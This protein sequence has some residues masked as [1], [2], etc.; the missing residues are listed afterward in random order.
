MSDYEFGDSLLTFVSYHAAYAKTTTGS[1]YQ[2]VDTKTQKRLEC[3][4]GT[5][6][7]YTRTVEQ[8]EAKYLDIFQLSRAMDILAPDGP[9]KCFWSPPYCSPHDPIGDSRPQDIGYLKVYRYRKSQDGTQ[10][11]QWITDPEPFLSLVLRDKILGCNDRISYFGP[12]S[13]YY[14]Q[15][16]AMVRT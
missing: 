7:F 14:C 15:M 2:I 9:G 13:G 16:D 8:D 3:V 12:P 1:V 11:Y 5:G 10:Y 4:P 6:S